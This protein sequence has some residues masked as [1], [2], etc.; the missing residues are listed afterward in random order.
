[1]ARRSIEILQC[2][3]CSVVDED[4]TGTACYAWAQIMVRQ[5]NGPFRISQ[6]SDG[7]IPKEI[8]PACRRELEAW[9][10]ASDKANTP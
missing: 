7:K 9:W 5:I 3:R 2:D 1:M 8:C 4:R 6:G 10:K